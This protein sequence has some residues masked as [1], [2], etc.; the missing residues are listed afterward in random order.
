MDNTVIGENCEIH[1]NVV[2]GADGFYLQGD[3]QSVGSAFPDYT[4]GIK[5][6]FRYKSFDIGALV[7][8]SKGGVY[9]S[10]SNM[11]G[12]YSGMLDQTVENNM[13]EDGLVLDGVLEDGSTNDINIAGIDYAQLHYH[14]F[15][16]PSAT[17]IFDASYM[18][19]R[20]VTFGYTL[21][22]LFDAVQSIRVSLYGR[23]LAVWGL[24][25]KGIDPETI[26]GGNGNIQ[27]IEGGLVP[28]TKSYGFNLQVKF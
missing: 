20:E 10:L 9:Y 8:I 27:G 19:L 26:V 21:P 2:I 25:N 7:D 16:T 14:G 28:G 4:A 23:N 1:N 15:G 22:K 6:T 5:N 13:R 18:K 11:W 24:D 3:L 12:M 17:S